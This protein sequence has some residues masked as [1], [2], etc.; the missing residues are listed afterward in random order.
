MQ[1]SSVPLLQIRRTAP[2]IG[3]AMAKE[4]PVVTLDLVG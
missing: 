3:G 1:R 4:L 2:T